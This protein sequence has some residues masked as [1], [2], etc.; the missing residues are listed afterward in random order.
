M[1]SNAL[2]DEIPWMPEGSGSASV[3]ILSIYEGIRE[4][5]RQNLA[6]SGKPDVIFCGHSE[7]G[8]VAT[9]AALDLVTNP[10]EGAGSLEALYTFGAT[11]LANPILG[12]TI[13]ARIGAHSFHV[14]RPNDI[15]ASLSLT[16]LYV[17]LMRKVDLPG[18]N[19]DPFNGTTFHPLS[20]YIQLLDPSGD[21]ERLKDEG[22]E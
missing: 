3:G 2:P 19:F 11:P 7:G 1:L 6:D 12:P 22:R 21:G 17:S 16:G 10:V 8:A 13:D 9:L 14:V 5:L 18:G 4:T 15:I 20:I